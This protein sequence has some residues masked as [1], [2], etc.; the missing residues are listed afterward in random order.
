MSHNGTDGWKE[1]SLP[2]MPQTAVQ[3]PQEWRYEVVLHTTSDPIRE[4]D[5]ALRVWFGD[6]VKEVKPC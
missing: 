1:P 4:V 2:G 5:R 6:I 3:G